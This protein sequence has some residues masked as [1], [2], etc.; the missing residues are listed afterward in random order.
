MEMDQYYISTSFSELPG[1]QNN[2]R[3]S[4]ELG[5][6][7]WGVEDS[8]IAWFARAFMDVLSSLSLHLSIS[9]QYHVYL[10]FSMVYKIK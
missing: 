3:H 2:Q 4:H 5:I 1:D 8:V 9:S 10:A 6:M 7:N